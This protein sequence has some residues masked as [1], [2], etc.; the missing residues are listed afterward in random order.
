MMEPEQ[1]NLLY[2]CEEQ[3]WWFVGMRRITAT[4]LGERI[5]PGLRCLEA[6]CG[7][8][9]N[10][11]FYAREYGWEVFPF[12]LSEHALRYAARRSLRRLVGS[13][14]T[15]LP[16]RDASFDCASCLDVLA[17]LD[18][19]QGAAALREFHRVLKPG[20]FLLLRTAALEWL[21]GGH[22]QVSHEAHRYRLGE[23]AGAVAHA[24][25]RVQ[26]QTYAN[27]LL[28]PLAFLKRKVLEP[29]RLSS[30]EG[31]VRPVAPWLNGLFLK[32]LM[33]ENSLLKRFASLP[34][35]VSAIV[36]AVKPAGE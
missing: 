30:R 10:S 25:F 26:R 5:R 8:G 17:L 23:L 19:E 31:D 35:G 33:V 20:G 36:L 22:S 15:A 28:L 29:L 12:D 1:Y 2:Q 11:L 16:Y 27:T 24:D 34:L 18:V 13:S 32:A 21:R 7:T 3:M 9:F 4:L 14:V 6:G